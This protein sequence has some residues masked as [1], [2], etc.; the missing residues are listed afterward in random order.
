[1]ITRSPK[2]CSAPAST[3]RT[4]RYRGSPASRTRNTGSPVSSAGTTPSTAIARSGSSRLTPDTPDRSANSLIAAP[5]SIPKPAPPTPRDGQAKS[6]TGR[7]SATSAST[8]SATPT[9]AKSETRPDPAPDNF[10]DKH[11]HEPG[12][13]GDVARQAV[14]L[15]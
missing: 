2:P 12:D 9:T 15:G 3:G 10:F 4:G 13:K 6:A 14:E 5:S 7:P 1:M 11:R 8:P